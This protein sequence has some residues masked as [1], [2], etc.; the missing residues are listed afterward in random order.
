ML[1]FK[2]FGRALDKQLKAR[3]IKALRHS[4]VDKRAIIRHLKHTF[5][6]VFIVS[7]REIGC[8]CGILLDKPFDLLD[9][10]GVFLTDF[11][12]AEIV[13]FALHRSD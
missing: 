12:F 4:N 11:Y 10:R 13:A 5:M 3:V 6:S 1:S 9:E 7:L 2:G 8:T